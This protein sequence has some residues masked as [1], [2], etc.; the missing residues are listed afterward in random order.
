MSDRAEGSLGH[1]EGRGTDSEEVVAE[2]RADATVDKQAL[3]QLIQASHLVTEDLDLDHVLRQL[4]TA[5]RALVEAHFAALGV[6]DDDGEIGRFIHV[7]MS[8]ELVGRIGDPPKGEGLLGAVLSGETLRLQNLSDDPRSVG[9]PLDHPAM[10]AFLGVPITIQGS[11]YGALYLTNPSTEAF[12]TEDEVLIEAL[13][14]TAATAITNACLF[15]RTRRAQRLHATLSE[16]TAK[17]LAVEDGEVFGVLAESLVSLL[18]AQLVLVAVSESV[19][20]EL[21]VDTAR[22]DRA[23]QIQGSSVPWMN[24]VLSR[25]MEGEP[26]ITP[27]RGDE[28]APFTDDLPNSS[29]IAVPLTISGERVAALCANRA[30]DETPFTKDDL[31]QLGDFAAQASLAVALAWARADRLRM[32]MVEE[33]ARIARDLHDHVIQKLFAT[34]LELQALA[35]TDPALT[36][37]L[38][39]HVTRIDSAISDIRTAIFALQTEASA[40]EIRHRVLEVVTEISP[41]LPSIPRVTFTGPIGLILEGELADDAV[42][43]MR[44]LLSNVARHAHAETVSVEF[45]ASDTQ[46]IITVDDDGMGPPSELA[47]RSGTR[48]LDARAQAHGGE[49]T[50]SPRSNGGTRAQ[51]QVPITPGKMS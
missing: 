36:D 49:F 26:G 28:P 16:A 34:G 10:E 43:V 30:A 35:S 37:A 25:A 3:V 50:L 6:L 11:T 39:S 21:Y 40:D 29:M 7:G 18:D 44:E 1:P 45:A 42:A 14:G 17:L 8:P 24:C 22:G 5:S 9:A 48:N 2:V 4:L 41:T 15:E 13:A 47:R 20:K 27:V 33:R 19:G 51:W 31:E 12:T 38:G 46:V 32:E 23:A